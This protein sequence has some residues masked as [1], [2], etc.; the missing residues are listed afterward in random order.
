MLCFVLGRLGRDIWPVGPLLGHK[1]LARFP[2][3]FRLHE[4]GPLQSRANSDHP[5]GWCR[6]GKHETG[7]L[8]M[9][10]IRKGQTQITTGVVSGGLPRRSD[11][12]AHCTGDR[13]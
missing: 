1:A 7:R 10:K 12:Q 8:A 5:P 2:L 3:G 13:P 9:H 6:S 4:I 11:A